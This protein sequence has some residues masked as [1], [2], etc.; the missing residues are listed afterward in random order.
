MEGLDSREVLVEMEPFIEKWT[1][2]FQGKELGEE[3]RQVARIA[4]W[5]RLPFYDSTRGKS[6]TSY[7]FMVVR[8]ALINWYRRERTYREYH[9]LPPGQ[10]EEDGGTWE[11][12]VQDPMPVLFGEDMVWDAWMSVLAEHEAY[13]LTMHIRYGYSLKQ[14]AKMCNVPYE[15]VKK[16]KQRALFRLK[17]HYEKGIPS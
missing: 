10:T 11:E 2:H 15:R 14:V 16:W 17:I 12:R 8:S 9:L 4:C 3:A 5:K 7:L 6:L 1:S 13:C